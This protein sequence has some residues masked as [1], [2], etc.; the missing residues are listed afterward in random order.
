VFG[1][2]NITKFCVQDTLNKN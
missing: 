2:L 1:F